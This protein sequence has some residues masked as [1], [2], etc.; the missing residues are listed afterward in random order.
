MTTDG[1]GHWTWAWR[2]GGVVD[3]GN[4]IAF[5]LIDTDG[6]T[7]EEE[8]WSRIRSSVYKLAR[9]IY[10]MEVTLAGTAIALTGSVTSEKVKAGLGAM[11]RNAAESLR[12]DLEVTAPFECANAPWVETATAVP[13][14]ESLTRYPS[15][16]PD[17]DASPGE[18]FQFKVDLAPTPDGMTEGDPVKLR[19]LPAGWTEVQVTAEVNFPAIVFERPEDGKGIIAIMPDGSSRPAVFRG[20]IR[21]DAEVGSIC[22]MS[23]MFEYQDRHAGAA[24]RRIPIQKGTKSGTQG[25]AVGMPPAGRG[26]QLVRNAEKPVLTVKIME[27]SSPGKLMWSLK[28]LQGPT[29]FKTVSWMEE[30]HLKEGTASFARDLLDRCPSLPPGRTHANVLRGIGERIWKATPGHFKS[31]FAELRAIHGPRFPIQFVTNDPHVPWEMMY[32]DANAGIAD[33]DHIFMSHPV[34]RWFG[35]CEGGMLEGFSKGRI[36]SFVPE[37]DDGSGLPDAVEEG[38]KLISEHGAE[39]GEATC[40]GFTNFLCRS[41]PDARV[42]ILHFAGHANPPGERGEAGSEGLRMSDGWVSHMEVNGGVVLGM[43]DGTFA[44]LNACSIGVANH[45]L[46][47]VG[48]WPASLADRGFGGILAPIWAIQDSLAS[49]VV[50]DQITGLLNGQTLGE[51]MREARE[52]YRNASATPYAYLCH[53]DVMARMS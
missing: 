50:H 19:D 23:V 48:G 22:K 24:V 38:R 42:S 20:R 35:E 2:K 7:V 8:P 31:L 47:V 29:R 46:G 9:E 53:G 17:G 44:V 27:G 39:I 33:A 16:T 21:P 28:A 4:W 25:I 10:G 3:A 26:I 1:A 15:V 30:I 49:S 11:F 13:P 41:Q 45:T 34:A 52:C 32:P 36:V 14:S 51:A 40:G 37:Y 43:E 5:G 6:P 18:I 12:N